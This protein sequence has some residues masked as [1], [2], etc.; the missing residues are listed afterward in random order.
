MGGHH[1]GGGFARGQRAQPRHC[2][3]PVD[4]SH[5]AELGLPGPV[6][7]EGVRDIGER[8]LGAGAFHPIRQH[9][10]RRGHPLRGLAGHHQRRQRGILAP[11]GRTATGSGACSITTCAFVPLTPN[12]DTPARRGL[13]VVGHSRALGRYGQPRCGLTRMGCQLVEVEVPRNVTV[14]YGEHGLHEPGDTRRRFQMTEIGLH[15]PDHQR[16]A[17]PGSPDR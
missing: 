15:R 8:H 14:A 1:A 10:R 5:R 7:V 11:L 17:P 12:D 16:R 2:L 4:G 6:M 13:P 9:R 3:A